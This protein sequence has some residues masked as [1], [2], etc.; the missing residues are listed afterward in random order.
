M[1]QL[2]PITTL[3]LTSH[4]LTPRFAAGANTVRG[5]HSNR[6]LKRLGFPRK[7]KVTVEQVAPEE[8]VVTRDASSNLPAFTVMRTAVGKQLP[9]YSAFKNGRTR[10][11]T[12]VRR[13][14]GDLDELAGALKQL[15]GTP[16]VNVHAGRIEVK[17]LHMGRINS[18]LENQL[19]F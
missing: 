8:I 5:V 18:F 15:C 7:A 2:R 9:V 10:Q 4:L 1:R 6:A 11:L 14:H 17:G 16:D 3:R 13:C 19:G 12:I